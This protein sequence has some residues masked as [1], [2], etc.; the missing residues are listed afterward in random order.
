[1]PEAPSLAIGNGR[2]NPKII[3]RGAMANTALTP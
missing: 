3:M 1:M 2:R